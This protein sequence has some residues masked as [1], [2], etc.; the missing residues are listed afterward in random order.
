MSPATMETKRETDDG[1]QAAAA[2]PSLIP[3]IQK[4]TCW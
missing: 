1:V 4:T 2:G 3:C